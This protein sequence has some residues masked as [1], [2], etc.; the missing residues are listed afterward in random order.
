MDNEERREL[1]GNI[2]NLG[3]QLYLPSYDTGDHPYE[4]H[5]ED[6]HPVCSQVWI[7]HSESKDDLMHCKQL[8]K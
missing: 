8:N 4:G 2:L 1:V 7:S 6:T 3:H 5:T